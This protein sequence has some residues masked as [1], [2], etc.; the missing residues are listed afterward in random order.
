M[1]VLEV[2]RALFRRALGEYGREPPALTGLTIERARGRSEPRLAV[3]FANGYRTAAAIAPADCHEFCARHG[4]WELDS[5]QQALFDEA[6][7][8]YAQMRDDHLLQLS[9]LEQRAERSRRLGVELAEIFRS[10]RL[11]T[12]AGFIGFGRRRLSDEVGSKEARERGLRLLKENLN[13]A[14]RQQYTKHQYFDVVGGKTGRRYRIRHGRMMNIDQIDKD[15]R[16]VCGWCFFPQGRLVAGDVMLAQKMALE[17][18]EADAL[19]IANRF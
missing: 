7:G 9:Y 14:Q 3:H 18:F 13:A 16:R 4:T 19:R 11:D 17:L 2:V 1:R 5:L 6:L 8:I 10:H 15:G 12:F